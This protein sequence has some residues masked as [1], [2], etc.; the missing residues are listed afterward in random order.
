MQVEIIP[1]IVSSLGAVHTR[2]LEALRKL[3]LSHDKEM[4]G[5]ARRVSEAAIMR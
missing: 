4:K 5:I 2:S 3:R 1:M